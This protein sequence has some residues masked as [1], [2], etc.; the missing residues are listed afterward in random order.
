MLAEV[1]RQIL[2]RDTQ[3]EIFAQPGMIQ[4]QSRIAKAMIESIVGVTIFPGRNGGRY[5]V[6][7]L[8][9]KTQSL[10]HFA[11]SHA[12]AISD[13]V[14]GHGSAA[15]AIAFIQILNHAFALVATGEI[16]INVGPFAAFLGKK[17]LEEQLHADRIDRRDAKRIADR[18][19]GSGSSSLRQNVLFAAEADQI[20][21]NEEVA[22]EVELFNEF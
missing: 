12:A 22:G 8:R 4:I 7:G 3:L 6:Q 1:T 15:L 19:V 16:E 14:G 2:H 18:T 10:A 13:D 11:R 9:I 5:F 21:D 20:P 17:P